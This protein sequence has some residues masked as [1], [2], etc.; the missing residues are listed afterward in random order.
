ATGT[1]EAYS[2]VSMR[3]QVGGVITK[4]SF[5]QGQDVKQ[6]D[7]LFTIDARPLEA[8]LKQA[9]A[10]LQRDT[11]QLQ[12]SR[13]QARRYAELVKKQYVSQEQYDQIKTTAD[14]LESVVEADKAAVENAKVQLSYCYIFAPVNGRTGSLLVNEGNLVRTN[15]ATPLVIINQ[16]NPIYVT[17]SLPE[18]NLPEIKARMGQ[19]TLK[20]LAILPQSPDNPEQGT[21]TFVDNAVDATTGT[22]KFR[23]TFANTARRLWP[24]QFVKVLLNLTDQPNAVVIPFQAIQSG[25]NTQLVFVVKPDRTVEV[26]PIVVGRTLNGEAIIEKG[27]KPGETIVTDGQFLLS[28]GTRVQ[29]KKGA[30]S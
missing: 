21:L 29:I 14:A 11:A 7:P 6:G 9:E 15:D 16:V 2:T 8:A 17:F 26:R 23:G 5:T 18:G 24:G 1:V 25:Q 22:I 3:A 30:E 28:Q 13:E 12:N 4:V 27:L 10:N 19:S 20:V